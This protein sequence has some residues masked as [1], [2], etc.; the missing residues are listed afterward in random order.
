M[1]LCALFE[2]YRQKKNIRR[3]GGEGLIFL[4]VL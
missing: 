4:L 3:R 2:R 1:T